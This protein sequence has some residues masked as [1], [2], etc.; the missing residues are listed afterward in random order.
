MII[1]TNICLPGKE[2][3]R[4]YVGEFKAGAVVRLHSTGMWKGCSYYI[5][6]KQLRLGL[7][8]SF[9]SLQ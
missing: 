9:N 5:Y 4:Y 7:K 3:I 8:Q 1:D 6:T 2:A